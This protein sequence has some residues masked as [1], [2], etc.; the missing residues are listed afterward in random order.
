MKAELDVVRAR[1]LPKILASYRRARE[2]DPLNPLIQAHAIL[3]SFYANRPE[4]AAIEAKKTRELFP[5]Y[6]LVDYF[7]AIVSWQLRDAEAM[8]R[9]GLP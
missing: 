2:L 5:D 3:F 1:D 9:L 7:E 6:W 4:I 8:A